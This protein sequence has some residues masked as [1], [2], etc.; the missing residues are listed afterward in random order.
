MLSLRAFTLNL[1][2]TAAP[3]VRS[4]AFLRTEDSAAD[5]GKSR[6]CAACGIGF[7]LANSLLIITGALAGS[8]GAILGS[9]MRKGGGMLLATIAPRAKRIVCGSLRVVAAVFEFL[10]QFRCQFPAGVWIGLRNPL[11]RRDYRR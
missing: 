3:P 2:R 11:K 8:C 4:G 9:M 10:C 5:S 1:Y 6:G 7:M